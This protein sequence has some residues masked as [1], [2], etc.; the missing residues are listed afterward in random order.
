MKTWIVLLSMLAIA[1]SW[2]WGKR[3]LASSQKNSSSLFRLI[4]RSLMAGALTYFFLISTALI[5][6]TFTGK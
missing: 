2:W 4:G 6:L 3:R 1:A 5:Y